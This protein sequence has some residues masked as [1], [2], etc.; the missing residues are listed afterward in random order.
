VIYHSNASHTDSIQSEKSPCNDPSL[1]KLDNKI[2]GGNNVKSTIDGMGKESVKM[3]NKSYYVAKEK[4]NENVVCNKNIANDS[5]KLTTNV[6]T[7]AGQISD[8]KKVKKAAKS[9]NTSSEF[10]SKTQSANT[11]AALIQH[12]VVA[13]T[14]ANITALAHPIIGPGLSLVAKGVILDPKNK[15]AINNFDFF[16]AHNSNS[17]KQRRKEVIKH[18]EKNGNIGG[19]DIKEAALGLVLNRDK[20]E[21]DGLSLKEFNTVFEVYDDTLK[22][23]KD[24]GIKIKEDQNKKIAST[25]H[26][27]KSDFDNKVKK[28]VKPKKRDAVVEKSS[29]TIQSVTQ[30][31]NS[32][33]A[34]VGHEE[35]TSIEGDKTIIDDY[36][37]K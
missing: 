25:F 1:I 10:M 34:W 4:F 9:V 16:N 8:S 14:A 13:H 15:N 18:L 24:G 32:I 21:S 2:F 11:K 19:I 36:I 30:N 6:A 17:V 5:I 22:N 7:L 29:A 27:F 20:K 35:A 23:I 31:L 26:S 12:A 33:T 28:E 37:E 3:M